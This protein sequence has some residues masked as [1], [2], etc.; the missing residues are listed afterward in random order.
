MADAVDAPLPRN[1]AVLVGF[2]E[3]GGYTTAPCTTPSLLTIVVAFAEDR[4]AGAQIAALVCGTLLVESAIGASHA[5]TVVAHCS[6]GALVITSAQFDRAA[7]ISNAHL[8]RWTVAV[9]FTTDLFHTAPLQQ[10]AHLPRQAIVIGVAGAIRHTAEIFACLTRTTLLIGAAV[11][12]KHTLL[13]AADLPIGAL[14]I[15]AALGIARLTSVSDALFIVVAIKV[16]A[17]LQG[18]RQ[19]SPP[20]ALFVQ[21]TAHVADAF[22]RQWRAPTVDTHQISGAFDIKTTGPYKQTLAIKAALI[23]IAV[24]VSETLGWDGDA[25]TICGAHLPRRTIVVAATDGRRNTSVAATGPAVGAV[26]RIQAFEPIVNANAVAAHFAPRAVAVDPTLQ[27]GIGD[28]LELITHKSKPTL[29]IPTALS[30]KLTYPFDT[31][32]APQTLVVVAALQVEEADVL[33]TATSWATVWIVETFGFHK[34]AEAVFAD[35]KLAAVAVHTAFWLKEAE[36]VV[37]KSTWTTIAIVETLGL[38]KKALAFDAEPIGP[39]VE[40]VET[41]G[42]FGET[43][44]VD[45]HTI[46]PAVCVALAL[47]GIDALALHADR[48]SGTIGV[49]LASRTGDA[50]AKDTLFGGGTLAVVDAGVAGAG[51][52]DTK[53]TRGTIGIGA[54]A[55]DAAPIDTLFVGLAEAVAGIGDTTPIDTGLP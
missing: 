47:R 46:G 43:C 51:V 25:L 48:V 52:F 12:H 24:V 38:F 34:E 32:L 45:A 37:A 8:V 1:G 31:R 13:V 49:A 11:A 53:L 4:L 6:C 36:S 29:H 28:A 27:V 54:A 21:G 23:I 20:D 55:I 19:T 3:E 40:V 14:E 35:P 33:D 39:T 41:L 44:T 2:T 30:H 50:V 42:F 7:L 22:R 5:H 18:T 16:G 15:V 26:A 10:I 9:A 17:A